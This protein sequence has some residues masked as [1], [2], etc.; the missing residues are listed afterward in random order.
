MKPKVYKRKDA[1][2]RI[3][4]YGAEFRAVVGHGETPA[5]AVADCERVLV[6]A[7]DR[8][9]RGASIG[10]WQDHLYVVS[11]HVDGWEYWIDTFSQCGYSVVLLGRQGTREMCVDAALQH[12]AQNLWTRDTHDA[13]MIASL[14]AAPAREIKD[15]IS[16]QRQMI[17]FQAQG[18]TQD[19][20]R[21]LIAQGTTAG[22][23]L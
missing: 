3:T 21:Q 1:R 19:Q 2:G 7:V 22:E 5:L 15:W 16:W 17:A 8:L 10:R 11:P 20:A 18:Y 4:G 12:L 13:E 14:P 9:Y 6:A 23:P